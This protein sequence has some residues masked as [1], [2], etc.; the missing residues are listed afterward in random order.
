MTM[1]TIDN[2]ILKQV[3]HEY[4]AKIRTR[5]RDFIDS[6]CDWLLA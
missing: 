3:D 4:S 5:P 2:L 6:R 1:T